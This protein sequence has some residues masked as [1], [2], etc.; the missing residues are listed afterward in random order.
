M[1][2][3]QSLFFFKILFICQR[4]RAQQWERQAEGEAGSLLSKEPDV[5]LDPRT[6]GSWPE[7]EADAQPTEPPRHPWLQSLMG[8]T[9]TTYLKCKGLFA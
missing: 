7:P 9:V 2:W 5:G 8:Q 3:S 1:N 4:E 6:A